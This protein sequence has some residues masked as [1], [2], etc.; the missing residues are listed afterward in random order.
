M[1]RR[2]IKSLAEILQQCLRQ[3]G[4]ET[5]LLQK[6]LIESWDKVAGYGISKYTGDKFI[7]NQTLFVKINNPSLRADLTMIHSRLVKSLNAEVGSNV[8]VDI[9]FY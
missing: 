7:K 3:D 2:D 1:F 9:K 5:P 4:L 8:I 6:R